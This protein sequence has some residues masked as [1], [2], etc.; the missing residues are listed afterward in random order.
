VAGFGILDAPDTRQAAAAAARSPDSR[1]CI[2]L[3]SPDGT[4]AAH[5]C[6][7]GPRYW[8]NGPPG[9]RT[10]RELAEG[11]KIKNLDAVIRG[12]CDHG[13]EE[14]RYRPSRRLQHLIRA[15]NATCTARG[16][17][18][19]AACCDLD[20]TDPYHKGGRSCQCNLAPLCRHH[21]LCKQTEGWRLEQPE[22][23]VL[24]GK[25]LNGNGRAAADPGLCGDRAWSGVVSG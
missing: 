21:H 12:P 24:T 11:L 18:R 3:L 14:D 20:H 23:G 4:A 17:N 19:R 1:W 9:F 15:R 7:P 13:Q 6:A 8:P 2:T 16:C 10:P 5:G 22:P 25:S